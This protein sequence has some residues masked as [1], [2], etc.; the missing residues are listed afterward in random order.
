MTGRPRPRPRPLLPTP[1]TLRAARDALPTPRVAHDEARGRARAREDE[2]RV[3]GPGPELEPLGERPHRRRGAR[4][5]PVASVVAL[6]FAFRILRASSLRPPRASP[7]PR[8]S[9]APCPP[10]GALHPSQS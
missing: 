1:F 2:G 4:G 3:R 7:D 6:A 9:I 5:A 10:P 8:P